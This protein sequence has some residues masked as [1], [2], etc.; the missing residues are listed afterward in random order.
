[1]LESFG[2][3]NYRAFFDAGVFELSELHEKSF[4]GD[5]ATIFPDERGE[6]P[7][8]TA[9]RQAGGSRYSVP[10]FRVSSPSV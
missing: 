10:I 7:G 9:N 1:M 3:E 4:V 8:F 6:A 2:R 5:I